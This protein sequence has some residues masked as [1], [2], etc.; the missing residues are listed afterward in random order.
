MRQL[1]SEH[2]PCRPGRGRKRPCEN[3]NL[4]PVGA[5]TRAYLGGRLPRPETVTAAPGNPFLTM[6]FEATVIAE[7]PQQL[8]RLET[9]E[10]PLVAN[11]SEEAKRLG[12]KF[13][14]GQR[15][16]VRR[17]SLDPGRGIIVSQAMPAK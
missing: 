2:G 12:V 16:L 3:A 11:L 14:T 8:F 1:P 4:S 15:V 5:W 6:T 17:A 9:E 13:R 7:L 10:G